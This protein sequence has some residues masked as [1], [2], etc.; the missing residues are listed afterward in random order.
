MNEIR[1]NFLGYEYKSPRSGLRLR[2]GH[3]TALAAMSFQQQSHNLLKPKVWIPLPDE[4]AKVSFESLRMLSK[5]CH[6][7][8]F[9]VARRY[10]RY[11]I[12][13]R[14]SIG[15]QLAMKLSDIILCDAV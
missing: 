3:P 4:V 7:G 6:T 2:S 10:V 14:I 12:H 5:P 11:P 1:P 8:L 9:S 15:C 13:Y